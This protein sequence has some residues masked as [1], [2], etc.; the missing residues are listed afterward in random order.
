MKFLCAVILSLSLLG[1][2]NNTPQIIYKTEYQRVEV[3]V[4]Y[5]LERPERPI[6]TSS[7]SSP[8]YLLKLLKYTSTLEVIIDEH[9]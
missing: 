8:S 4:L 3:P 1:C 9:K 7:D 5:K 2:A 6:Y